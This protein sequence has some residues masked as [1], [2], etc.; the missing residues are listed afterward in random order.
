ME[1]KAVDYLKTNYPGFE[2]YQYSVAAQI[3]DGS[4]FNNMEKQ[5]INTNCY[6]YLVR[7]GK[8]YHQLFLEKAEDYFNHQREM[9]ALIKTFK[10]IIK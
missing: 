9:E 10:P 8:T 1:N 6:P 3:S 7:E 2:D 4:N 5:L